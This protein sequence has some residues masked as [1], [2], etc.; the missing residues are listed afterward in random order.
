VNHPGRNGSHNTNTEYESTEGVAVSHEADPTPNHNWMFVTDE[1]G[2]GVVPGGASCSELP[3]PYGNGGVH[4]FNISEGGEFQY[5]QDPEGN[6]AVF[7]GQVLIPS[8]TFC[9][10]HVMEQIK[11][12][13]R[14]TIAWYIQGTKIVDYF[15]DG[16]G[17]WTFREIASAVPQN[18][19]ATTC[20]SQVFKIK[21]N[22]DGTKT[23]Y[24]MASDIT[25]GIDIFTWT[26]PANPTGTPPPSDAPTREEKSALSGG[27]LAALALA[28]VPRLRRR[29]RG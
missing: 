9:T 24:F 16:Q 20:T 3:N 29:L 12:E 2:G 13:Q 15:I 18:P 8:G 23:Y 21:R 22:D 14:F 7:I 4:V 6:K 26:G 11:G 17:R 1:R 10:A 19:N 27:L 5:A 28:T 25:R